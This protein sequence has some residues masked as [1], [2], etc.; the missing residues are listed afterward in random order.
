MNME[1]L[2]IPKA[3]SGAATYNKEDYYLIFTTNHESSNHFRYSINNDLTL[4]LDENKCLIGIDSF[5]YYQ[6]WE[7]LDLLLPDADLMGCIQVKAQYDTHG[8]ASAASSLQTN[9]LYDPS[10]S[11]LCIKINWDYEVKTTKKIEMG[12]MIVE[13]DEN[14]RIVCIWFANLSLQENP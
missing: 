1:T 9:Y 6:N 2:F 5:T 11:I 7:V 14:K 3:I 4:W 8:I 10:N 12:D 13:I